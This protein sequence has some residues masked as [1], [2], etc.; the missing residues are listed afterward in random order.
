MPNMF[1][2][3]S[4]KVSGVPGHFR[5]FQRADAKITDFCGLK[6]ISFRCGIL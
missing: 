1:F 3:G 5:E 2:V 4:D 6:R